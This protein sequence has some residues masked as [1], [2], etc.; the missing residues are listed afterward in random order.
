VITVLKFV[1]LALAC[2]ITVKLLAVVVTSA[3]PVLAG[4]FVI[5]LVV[6]LV[7]SRSEL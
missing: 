2:C 3:I 4:A 7:R 6:V 5:L 1:G